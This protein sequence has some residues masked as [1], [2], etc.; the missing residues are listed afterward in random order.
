MTVMGVSS[1]S[2]SA[3]VGEACCLWM[4]ISSEYTET[5]MGMENE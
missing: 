1:F 5:I 3:M 4:D 2:W